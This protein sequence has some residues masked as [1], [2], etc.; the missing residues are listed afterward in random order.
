MNRY[1][2]RCVLW[3]AL[4]LAGATPALAQ[5]T[6]RIVGRVVDAQ[7]GAGMSNVMIEV[8]GTTAR[9]LSGVDGR[10]ALPTV[11]AGAVTLR[12]HSIGYTTKSV[13]GVT[14]ATNATI[15]QNLTM[16]VAAVAMAAIEVSAA[17]ERGSVARALDEQR[18]AAGIVNAITAEEMSRSP[19]GDAASAMQRVSGVTVEDGRYIHVRGLGER[20]TTA[21]LNGARVPS[22][23]PER[24]VV[25]LDIFPS[26]LLQTI[27]ATKTFTPDLS[28]DFSGA[29]V[30]IRTR[31]FPTERQF[32]VS[33]G[34]GLND[35]VTGATLFAAPRAGR[36]WLGF[37]GPERS[38]PVS[39]SAA[40]NFTQPI[41]HN[42]FN[43][44]INDFRNAW[45][46]NKQTGRG[47]SS[48][49]MS[50]GGTDALRGH[51]ISYLLSGTYAYG[52][53]VHADEVRARTIAGEAG[54][55]MEVDRFAG[56]TGRTTVLWGGLAS[57]STLFGQHTRM[58]F[59][60]TYTR[61]ADNDARS[62]L[63][64]SENYGGIP[65]HIQRLRF[66][67]RSVHSAQL[68][69][70]HALGRHNLEWR[71]TGSGVR[72]YEPDRSEF[73]YAQTEIGAPF[74]WFAAS[75]EGAVRT[76][77]DLHE[78]SLEASAAYN[79]QLS[80]HA[81]SF[82]GLARRTERDAVNHAYSISA[83]QLPGDGLQLSPEEIFDGRYTAEGQGYMRVTPLSQGGSYTADDRLLAAFAMA[84]VGF[85]ER[86]QLIGGARVERSELD[87]IA[88]ATIGTEQYPSNPAYTD[89]LPALAF[90]VRFGESHNVRLAATQT[91]ARP[92][93]RELANVQY[94]D[95][96]GGE[97][98]VGNP[99][100]K[101]TLVQNY[102][103]R[104]E[105]YPSA[106]EAVSAAVFA[107]NFDDPIEKVYRATSGTSVVTYVNAESARNIGV[108]LELRKRFGFMADALES[109]TMF[110]NATVMQ[111]EITIPR[112]ASSQTSTSRR[113]VGQ[114][115][116]VVN[117]GLTWSPLDGGTS[118]TVL[119][120]IVGERIASAGELPLPDV[121]EQPR[122][123]L[124]VSLRTSV[125]NGVS[126]K[127]DV[128]N[129]LDAPYE[130]VQGG[131]I[132][133]SYRAGRSVSFGLSW[134]Q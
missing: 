69:A 116:Y 62:E 7:S 125:L 100:L 109:L 25:P 90:N 83:M 14:V 134:R 104:W 98:V 63:G 120:N 27:T 29:Q 107:K 119:Y 128:K 49:G 95:V 41:D 103:V 57:A 50:L 131:V 91:L 22:P 80:R 28:G 86:V 5:T 52:E 123:V 115:P 19:D 108:E 37:A 124:D 44:M 88:Q 31:E 105:W 58:F 3:L 122:N 129:V 79:V 130:L 73:V 72:R 15:E 66:V 99:D 106:G 85:G 68:G 30:D 32:T 6:G 56:E 87:L 35:R 2:G 40:G 71:V 77:S 51:D 4:V 113:M 17:A 89:V 110:S 133:E 42:G 33:A 82:G 46:P 54:S 23:E 21:S 18:N 8:V 70:E 13:T 55:V 39:V 59:N 127:L 65:L 64:A 10:Y 81:L 121:K 12:A 101:R 48:L 20:Y 45:S 16:D 34:A 93:Y 26:G 36:E 78:S 94:R 132:R 67:E 75:N 84:T 61:T 114:A 47:N 24:K 43:R 118:A 97:N 74:R 117:A 60:G 111:S 11:P 96:L 53:E 38:L 102:D 126:L 92:E 76:F 1:W 9:T 112:A